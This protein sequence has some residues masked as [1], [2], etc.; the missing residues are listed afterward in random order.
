MRY[1]K[2]TQEDEPYIGMGDATPLEYLDR[3]ALQNEV[4]ED[5][6]RLESLAIE[7]EGLAILT[8]QPFICGGQ[9]KPAKILCAM[10]QISFE[11]IPGIPANSEDA[12]HDYLCRRIDASKS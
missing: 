4:F 7:L 8:T 1:N 2:R 6:I 12:M 10:S 5:D 3:L 9:A 11:R